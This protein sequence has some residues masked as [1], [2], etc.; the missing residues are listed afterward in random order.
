MNK[1]CPITGKSC[2]N[3]KA[4]HIIDLKNNN[5]SKYINVCFDCLCDI[6]SKCNF[7]S[8]SDCCEF[9]GMNLEQL[10]KNSKMG[11]SNCY[12]KYE[13]FFILSLEKLQKIPNREKKEIKHVGHVPYLW[14]MQQAEKT[15]P[16]EFLLELNNKLNNFIVD[17]KYE[18]AKEIKDKIKAF[19]FFLKKVDEFKNDEEQ[20]DLIK[21]QIAEFIYLFRESELKE[22]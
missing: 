2:I 19:E 14:K 17:E 21:K 13:K 18:K 3:C 12:N 10:L 20:I 16:K 15:D 9:C 11:C 8:N 7:S 1:I 6:N 4:Y 5:V 22:N